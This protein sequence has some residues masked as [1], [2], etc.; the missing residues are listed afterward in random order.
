MIS[1]LQHPH[2]KAFHAG[3]QAISNAELQWN[4]Q[5]V[6]VYKRKTRCNA[7]P[8]G[9]CKQ[10]SDY[11]VNCNVNPARILQKNKRLV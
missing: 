8:I 4:K 5:N 11:T 6:A 1:L 2:T 10:V 9:Q 7:G 3:F